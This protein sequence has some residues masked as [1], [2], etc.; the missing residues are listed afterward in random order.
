VDVSFDGGDSLIAIRALYPGF[1]TWDPHVDG[2]HPVWIAVTAQ[3]RSGPLLVGHHGVP[4]VAPENTHAGIGLA[5]SLGIP[6]IEFDVRF[7]KDSIPVLMHDRDVS[8]TSNGSGFV[9]QLTLTELSHLD[10]G[11]WFGLAFTGERV[12]TLDS[13]LAVGGACGFSHIELDM[14]SFSPLGVDSALARVGRLINKYGLLDRAI[15]A[16]D[17]YSL[18]RAVIQIPGVR[19]MTYGGIVTSSLADL[20][21]RDHVTAIGVR[22]DQYGA[23]ADQLSR[24]D[25]AGVLVGVWAPPGVLALNALRPIPRSITSDWAWRFVN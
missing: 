20:L 14:K 10:I 7:S 6:G 8:R 19:T 2:L 22:F 12:P 16:S 5:C 9:D 15:I 24:L 25:S 1:A 3:Q 17:V 13:V 21:I 11:S 18:R 4:S 23:S